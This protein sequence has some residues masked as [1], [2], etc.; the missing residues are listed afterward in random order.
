MK[1]LQPTPETALCSKSHFTDKDTERQAGEVS[2]SKI[3]EWNNFYSCFLCSVWD[4]NPGP[5]SSNKH[6]TTDLNPWPNFY[7]FF[8]NLELF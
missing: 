2:C 6:S 7:N 3:N 1:S 4:L 8:V 5:C